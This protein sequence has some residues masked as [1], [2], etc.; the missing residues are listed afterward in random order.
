MDSIDDLRALRIARALGDPTRFVIYRHIIDAG[1]MRCGD[2]GVD[3]PVQASTVSHHLRVLSEAGLI[4]SRRE[5][6]GVY[7]R[8]ISASLGGYLR[9]MRN[10]ERKGRLHASSPV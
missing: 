2:V 3:T 4:G 10:L 7:Y 5:G 6:Q 9:F 1:E 8:V